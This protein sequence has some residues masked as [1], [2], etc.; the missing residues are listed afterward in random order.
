[1]AKKQ[2]KPMFETMVFDDYAAAKKVA[3]K[4]K[5]KNVFAWIG[6]AVAVWATYMG[7][8]L[9]KTNASEPTYFLGMVLAIVAYILAGGLGRALRFAGRVALFGWASFFFPISL[10]TGLLGFILGVY[11]FLFFPVVFVFMSF[12][13]HNRDAKAAND[14]LKAYTKV[15]F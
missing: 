10:L 9:F 13:Q 1:M 4:A 6:M 8:M 15:E 11:F 2:K 5:I 12:I 3:D 14:Y 7:I